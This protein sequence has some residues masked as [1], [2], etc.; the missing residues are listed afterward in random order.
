M[1]KSG[2]LVLPGNRLLAYQPLELGAATGEP[3]QAALAGVARDVHFALPGD[4]VIEL[5]DHVGTEVSLDAHDALR[6]E[7]A[8]RAVDVALELDAVLVHGAQRGERE[9]LEAAGVGEDRPVPLHELVQSAELAHEVVAGTQMQVIRVGEDHLR[10]HRAQVV[11]VERLDRGERPHRHERRRVDDA[12]RRAEPRGARGAGR[13]LECEVE[14][15]WLAVRRSP[16]RRRRNRSD[17]ARRP[18]PGTRASSGRTRQ[19]LRRA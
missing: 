2:L 3:A 1:G 10:V 6:G 9:H 16:S 13:R 5:H 18:P 12:V 11:G 19:P 8:S 4:D 17:T 15:H 14:A 7:V